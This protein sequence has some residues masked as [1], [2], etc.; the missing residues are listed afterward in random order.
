I[1]AIGGVA[2]KSPLVIQI[3]ADVLGMPIDI[4]RSEQ[5][6]ALGAAMFAAVVAGIYPSVQEAQARMLPPVERSVEPDMARAA[7]Y[8]V[9]YR[10]YGKLGRF[11][12]EET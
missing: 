9:L 3:V 11:V 2:K 4:I 7:V 8:D 6:V 12:E 1:I 5:S 10:K